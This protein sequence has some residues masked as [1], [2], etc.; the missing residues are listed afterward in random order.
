MLDGLIAEALDRSPRLR[1]AGERIAASRAR[2]RPAGS[3]N[4]P[5]VM[6]GIGQLPIMQPTLAGSTMLMAGVTQRIPT[7]GKLALRT[8]AAERD[9]DAAATARDAT[10]L[11]V[12]R[13]V[14]EAYYDLVFADQALAIAERSQAVLVDVER[15]S[16]ALYGAGTGGQ[17]DVL[18]A[19]V[20]TARLAETASALTEARRAALAR[21]NAARDR[22]S[23]TPVD[24]ARIPA[25][26]AHAAIGADV[27]AVRFSSASLGARVSGSPLP[28][29]A[30]LQDAALRTSPTLRA[31]DAR[32][33][34]QAAR[35][36]LARREYRPDVDVSVQYIHRV[37]APDLVTAQVSFPL[38]RHRAA[39]QDQ[40]VAE[41]AAELAALE[42]ER[43]ADADVVRGRIATIG[44]DLERYRT[45]LA[46]Y[47]KAILP[48]SR[49]GVTSALAAFQAGRASL[50]SVLDLQN[51]VF[52]YETAYHR[53]L[54]DFAKELAELEQVTGAEVL[55]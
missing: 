15:V 35:V 48:Q 43:A 53:A 17:Q 9:A 10:R 23:D 37:A 34:A 38:P 52:N 40:A 19:R 7:S 47:A 16:V 42:A 32:I 20:E 8:Q 29:L 45:A 21:L 49:A 12:V 44:S 11:D 55:P 24:G 51:T 4:D 22:A 1:A 18:K 5:V 27:A 41:A 2:I 25:R 14:K 39:K 6:A 30:E 36:E 26:I 54:T 3:W 28:P 33:A 46:L 13:A 31:D 50:L